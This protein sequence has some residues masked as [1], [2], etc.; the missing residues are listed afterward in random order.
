MATIQGVYLALFGRPADPSGLTYFNGVTSNGANLAGIA[1][2][3]NT[4]EYKGRFTGKTDTEIVN[5]IFQSLFGRTGDPDGVAFFVGELAAGRQTINT[6][7]INILDGAKGADK[8]LVDKKLV[9]A[10]LFT[11]AIDTPA[12]EAAYNG[13]TNPSSLTKAVDFLSK[14]TA[15]STPVTQAD[16]DGAVAG[17]GAGVSDSSQTILINSASTEI[18]NVDPSVQEVIVKF[19]K[20][21]ITPD[22]AFNGKYST[23]VASGDGD[24]F[25][26]LAG[27]RVD[28]YSDKLVK[29]DASG[30]TGGAAVDFISPLGVTVIGSKAA[31]DIDFY[32][33]DGG[34]IIFGP[35]PSPENGDN[36]II[37]SQSNISTN[38]TMDRFSDFFQGGAGDKVDISAFAV[39]GGKTSISKFSQVSETISQP[40]ANVGVSFA[41]NAVAVADAMRTLSD[42]TQEVGQYRYYVDSNN[43]GIYDKDTDLVFQLTKEPD[44]SY[45]TTDN[46][47][48]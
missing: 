29:F 47:I 19:S 26:S 10:D 35:K 39:T 21:S 24:F 12:E 27:S 14:V 17:L 36:K 42:G 25:K 8:T 41:G 23:F 15:T 2:L 13:T 32:S 6:I 7:A 4:N 30:L 46:F 44:F 45:M 37:Y 5:T 3:S 18:Y 28:V 48:F 20:G 11:T 31:D 16:A 1:D 33:P 22:G 9:A 38:A 40:D 34:F 43:N